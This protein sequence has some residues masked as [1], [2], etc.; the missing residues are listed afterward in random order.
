MKR[1]T[2]CEVF[3]GEEAKRRANLVKALTE[4]MTEDLVSRYLAAI[5]KSG[6]K[7]K[8]K[9]TILKPLKNSS[10]VIGGFFV[11]HARQVR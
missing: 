5:G 3:M 10:P 4:P 9:R 7:K 11:Q 8:T 6:K 2:L 1:K